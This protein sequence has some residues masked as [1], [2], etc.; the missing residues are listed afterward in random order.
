MSKTLNSIFSSYQRMTAATETVMPPVGHGEGSN[1]V[2]PSQQDA[3]GSL[4]AAYI[5]SMAE[6]NYQV[7]M[8]IH[9]HDC[10]KLNTF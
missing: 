1:C 3:Y 2:E 4:Q 8:N 6:V 5:A 7:D 9:H 10:I